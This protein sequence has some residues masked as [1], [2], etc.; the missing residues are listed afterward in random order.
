MRSVRVFIAV[1]LIVLLSAVNVSQA[2]SVYAI[3]QHSTNNNGPF[4]KAY[5]TVG[6]EIEYQKTI[7]KSDFGYGPVGIAVSEVWGMIF[8]TYESDSRIVCISAKNLEKKLDYD[9]G[10]ENLAGIVAD[11]EK[12]KLYVVQRTTG[13]LY[14]YHWDV[15]NE[16]LVLE[17]A[18]ESLDYYQLKKQDESS[19]NSFG[20]ALDGVNDLLWATDASETVRSYETEGFTYSDEV[21][22]PT[23]RKAVGIAYD[24]TG[25]LYTGGY[26]AANYYLVRLDVNDPNQFTN[27]IETY[28]G[29]TATGLAVDNETGYVYCT[30]HH[31]DVRVYDTDLVLQYTVTNTEEGPA[32]VAVGSEYKDPYIAV[33]KDDGVDPNDVS[34]PDCVGP[35]DEFT[36]TITVDPNECDHEWVTVVDYLPAEVVYDY[37]GIFAIMYGYNDP[38]YSLDDHTYTWEIGELSATDS[39][40]TLTLKVTVKGDV[41]P[42]SV[43]VNR[44]TAESDIAYDEYREYTPVCCWGGD[45]IYVDENSPGPFIGTS[46]LTAYDKLEDALARAENCGSDVWVADGTYSPGT[47]STDSFTVPANI[48]V[49]GGFAGY[50]ATNPDERDWKQYRTVLTGGGANNYVVTVGDKSLIDG[51]IIVQSKERGIYGSGVIFEVANCVVRDNIEYGIY[52][53]NSNATVRWTIVGNNGRDGVFNLSTT[54]NFLSVENC[55]IFGNDWNGINCSGSI[56]TVINSEVYHNGGDGTSYCGIKL[57]NPFSSADIRNCT[58]AVNANEGVYLTGSNGPV[59]TNCIV[60]N[61]NSGN[62]LNQF[63]GVDD[64]YYSCVNGYGADPNNNPELPDAY[65]N[66]GADPNFAYSDSSLGNFHLAFGSLCKN[67][68]DNSV[69]DP[70]NVG[71]YDIDGQDRIYG[72][73]VDIGSDEVT[74][75]E[76]SSVFDENGDGIVNYCE[77]AVFG[78]SWGKTSTD[79]NWIGTHS[80]YNYDNDGDSANIVDLA[81]LMV[82]C[83]DY[84]QVWL[85]TACW[86]EGYGSVYD[87]YVAQP[88]AAQ[89][90]SSMMMVVESVETEPV[91]SVIDPDEVMAFLEMIAKDKDVQKTIKKKDL[92]DFI[93][94]VEKYLYDNQP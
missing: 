63:Y 79:P 13:Q 74:C 91:E 39:P 58:I 14:V 30:T 69:V 80:N 24:E 6:N 20:L 51:C 52:S 41:E 34:L 35:G 9:T 33:T 46:W 62:L 17:E 45:V 22:N 75:S 87:Y 29:A 42:S 78:N 94:A 32:G 21:Q 60:W 68:G 57:L 93:S 55:K 76:V 31:H 19:L 77:F 12:E 4:V 85:W 37:G 56:A 44:V 66:F 88:A 47:K 71:E 83:E 7:D 36:Y 38:N 28:I 2:K 54:S 92:L 84:P 43:L 59:V 26:S 48:Y 3:T 89:Q 72:T 82:L 64:V 61:N 49:Y 81:D 40:V 70:N 53:L 16:T 1:C 11:D 8:L 27:T 86:L 18:S 23:D 25:Y 67:A 73:T 5:K 10:V 50:G 65:G 90:S 15:Y